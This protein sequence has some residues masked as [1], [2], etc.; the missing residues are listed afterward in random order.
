LASEEA[1]Q[2]PHKNFYR[3]AKVANVLT[4]I[5]DRRWYKI[6]ALIIFLKACWSLAYCNFALLAISAFT[7][8]RGKEHKVAEFAKNFR[9]GKNYRWSLTVTVQQDS[10]KIF[11]PFG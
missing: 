2:N 4:K 9:C 6:L 10:W 8:K 3:V 1:K 11:M 5:T 7:I